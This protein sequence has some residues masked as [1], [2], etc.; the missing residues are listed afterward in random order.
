MFLTTFRP[1]LHFPR[2]GGG[3][4]LQG[5]GLSGFKN[6]GFGQKAPENG[7]KGAILD[8]FSD[9]SGKLFLKNVIKGTTR[10]YEVNFF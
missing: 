1:P 10:V 6:A 8:S 3:V 2:G 4:E 7:A 5:F 9:I